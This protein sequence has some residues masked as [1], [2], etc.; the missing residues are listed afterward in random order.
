MITLRLRV[1]LRPIGVPVSYIDRE[2]EK[3][4]VLIGAFEDGQ[5]V[6]CCVLTRRDAE[7]VQLRQMAVDAKMQ[8]KGIGSAVLHFAE[9]TAKEKGYRTLMMHARNP[10]VPFYKMHGYV[11][12]GEEFSEVGTGH[13][14]MQKSLIP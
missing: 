9:K 2:K 8:H 10:V 5:I 7:T 11:V 3:E 12:V 1:L 6:G 4:D 13:H 14:K